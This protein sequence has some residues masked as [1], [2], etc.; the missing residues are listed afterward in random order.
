MKNN[1][2]NN[3]KI[4]I[5]FFATCFM[6]ILVL[7]SSSVVSQTSNRFNKK[8]TNSI[9]DLYDFMIDFQESLNSDQD[10]IRNH[11]YTNSKIKV[12]NFLNEEGQYVDN[13][14]FLGYLDSLKKLKLNDQKLHFQVKFFNLSL[15]QLKTL[16]YIDVFQ[17][18]VSVEVTI[19]K[20]I[21][22]F[23]EGF[24][25]INRYD[26]TLSSYNDG[27][28]F[29]VVKNK[30]LDID[31]P[32]GKFK[33]VDIEKTTHSFYPN[34][35]TKL[36]VPDNIQ[37]NFTGLNTDIKV[38]N[39]DINAVGKS[40]IGFSS[41]VLVEYPLKKW[42]NS[43]FSIL[44]GLGCT[45]YNSTHK[46]EYLTQLFNAIDKDN[47]EYT[48]K[49]DFEKIEQDINLLY[50]DIPILLSYS[51]HFHKN[52]VFQL[53]AGV[54][55]SCLIKNTVNQIPDG[56]INYLGNYEI[57]GY[58]VTFEHLPEYGYGNYE[59]KLIENDNNID[60]ILISA[61]LKAGYLYKINK[62]FS[63][64][65]SITYSQAVNN[66][67]TKSKDPN[68]LSTGY[69]NIDPIINFN[70]KIEISSMGISFGFAWNLKDLSK[71]LLYGKLKKDTKLSPNFIED[72][73]VNM[74]NLPKE[75]YI[76]NKKG[77]KKIKVQIK[78]SQFCEQNN[79]PARPPAISYVSVDNN[80]KTL[81]KGL[82]TRNNK[83][84]SVYNNPNSSNNKTSG[85]GIYLL[86]PFAHQ[87]SDISN[88]SS[89][90]DRDVFF[91]HE[92]NMKSDALKIEITELP[93]FNLNI[94]SLAGSDNKYSPFRDKY[95]E[96]LSEVAEK[97]FEE[98][99][100]C[101]TFVYD[102]ENFNEIERLGVPSEFYCNSCH[103][104]IIQNALNAYIYENLNPSPPDASWDTK[105]KQI[106]QNHLLPTRR[107]VTINLFVSDINRLNR[108]TQKLI[109]LHE[110]LHVRYFIHSNDFDAGDI[111]TD[112]KIT[113]S[114][115]EY[116]KTN[117][118]RLF[119]KQSEII[120]INK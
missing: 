93:D 32:I 103:D 56:Y 23:I 48:K 110:S 100:E 15:T 104:T 59:T 113:N 120:L 2:N 13:D 66:P 5:K 21:H 114:I 91:I 52:H 98:H 29:I 118:K 68:D 72:T 94:V 70:D 44:T 53:G 26:T 39:N 119:L 102:S 64:S 14:I 62:Q 8:H 109:D 96:K 57:D 41:S 67:L 86:K 60:D 4:S 18:S 89:L 78:Q 19:K 30:F 83:N 82:I 116:I 71:P 92:N 42:N 25:E 55:F 106:L 75:S 54:K 6:L 11:F 80:K 117:R 28:D 38:N 81:T 115:A 74:F 12:Y 36:L 73:Y 22:Q 108:I 63:L 85:N 43:T 111:V 27:L 84:I 33:V 47:Q 90:I 97:D 17:F 99:D 69:G 1:S 10:D 51:H 107:N 7:L 49:S 77:D 46:I 87:I 31:K 79:N 40:N 3:I 95:L 37:L 61:D 112:N 35:Y 105:L 9:N 24:E 34:N 76:V 65:A 50:G 45:Q 101:F 58:N 88:S 16:K 20:E